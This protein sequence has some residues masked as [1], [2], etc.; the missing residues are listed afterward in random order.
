MKGDFENAVHW[1]DAQGRIIARAAEAVFC[2][3]ATVPKH[4][5]LL[6]LYRRSTLFRAVSERL[7]RQVARNRILFSWMT[8]IFIGE[9][10]SL[11]RYSVVSK[12]FGI[13][14]AALAGFSAW[15]L[16]FQLPELVGDHGLLPLKPSLDRFTSLRSGESFLSLFLDFPTLAWIST[17]KGWILAHGI[18]SGILGGG[19]IVAL[20]SLRRIKVLE[21]MAFWGIYLLY[22]SLTNMGQ[23]FTGYQWESLLLETLF[24]AAAWSLHRSEAVLFAFRFLL[25]RLI[26][27]SGLSKIASGDLAWTSLEA[28]KFHWETQPLPSPIAWWLYQMPL[29]FQ[30]VATALTLFIETA[31]AFLILM[32]RRFRIIGFFLHTGL[33]ILIL[34]TGSYGYFNLLTLLLCFLLLDDQFLSARTGHWEVARQAAE[35][36]GK[37]VAAWVSRTAAAFS[38]VMGIAVLTTT[39]I[40]VLSNVGSRIWV[41]NSFGLFA[42]MTRNRDEVVLE[43]SEDGK[44][45]KEISFRFKPGRLDSVLENFGWV[46]PYQPRLDWQMWFAALGKFENQPW[47]KELIRKILHGDPEVAKL[48]VTHP[49]G[50]TPPRMVRASRYRYHFTNPEEY[51]KTSQR[52]MR[53]RLGDYSQTFTL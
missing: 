8:W 30:Q 4:S 31:G 34:T 35:P 29:F 39:S 22:L 53:V 45:W 37:A 47:M 42:V 26:L 38:V 24:L 27:G 17:S 40:P 14:L 1:T 6:S 15:T 13:G 9:D 20:A 44:N 46:T 12:V 49:F 51:A 11:P 28:L 7:Y 3:L 52:W 32:P 2:A 25:F 16:A 43:G 21:P 19:A 18:L 48:G 50:S 10:L 36:Q 23:V 5:W 33:Q 41:G